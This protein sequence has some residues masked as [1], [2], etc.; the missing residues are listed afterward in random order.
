[1]ARIAPLLIA[2]LPIAV[3]VAATPAAA[4]APKPDE[5]VK[6]RQGVLTAMKW[7]FAPIA[8]VAKGETPFTEDTISRARYLVTLAKLA[9]TGFLVPSGNDLVP[10]SK[11][12]PSIW[13]ANRQFNNGWTALITESERLLLAATDRDAAKLKEQAAAVG[14]ACKSCHDEFRLE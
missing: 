13:T 9:Q 2:A 14:K 1:M 4:Q 11:A 8:A 12:K 6:M 3:L 7:Q 5:A 10:A